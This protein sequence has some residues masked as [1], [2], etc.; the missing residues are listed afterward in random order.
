VLRDGGLL[1][2]SILGRGMWNATDAGEWQED[3]TGMCVLRAGQPWSLGGPVVFHSDWWVREHWGRGFDVIDLDPG[4][5]PTT[6]G[7]VVLKKR[8]QT[9]DPPSLDRLGDDPREAEALRHN[10]ELLFAED[11]KL[12]PRYLTM[13][14]RRPLLTARWWAR[15]L[16][17]RL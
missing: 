9:I 11:R 8:T 16:R 10:L 13:T 3:R 1:M 4:V 14:A 2:I 5:E 12:R 15:R 6:H 17:S 7:W